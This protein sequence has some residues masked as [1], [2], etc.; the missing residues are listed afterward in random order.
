MEFSIF[1]FLGRL[2]GLALTLAVIVFT[3]LFTIS[4][5]DSVSLGFWPLEARLLVPLWVVGIGGVAIGLLLGAFSMLVPLTSSSLERRRLSRKMKDLER[6][7]HETEKDDQE[8][9][10]L[11]PPQF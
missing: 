7:Q 4:N 9:S 2:L 6:K 8:Q 1:S 10:A 11:P 5:S 3:I